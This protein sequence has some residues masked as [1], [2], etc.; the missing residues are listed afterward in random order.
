MKPI[1]FFMMPVLI[2]FFWIHFPFQISANPDI[3]VDLRLYKGTFSTK[4]EDKITVTTSY[5]LRPIS[6]ETYML[7]PNLKEEREEI[8]KV[9]N[10]LE[11][12]L[13]TQA[14]WGWKEGK[15][16]KKFQIIT[17]D[18]REF[19]L[20]FFQLDKNDT[21]KL[22]VLEKNS[23][24]EKKLLEAEIILPKEK[25]SIFGFENS[26]GDPYFISLQRGKDEDIQGKEPLMVAS[27]KRP[28]LIRKIEPKY[29]KEAL[30]N[31][32]SGRV[33]LQCTTDIYG[34]VTKVDLIEGDPVLSK[35]AIE[36]LSQ[37]IY[38]PYIVNN[39]PTE[40][41]FTV[42]TTFHLNGKEKGQK[43][44][45]PEKR[46]EANPAITQKQL[47][48]NLRNQTFT[49]EPMDFEF[50]NA[51]LKNVIQFLS[52]VTNLNMNLDR[53]VKGKVTCKFKQMPWDKAL[54][55]FL[56]DNGLEIILSDGQLR[57]KKQKK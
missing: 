22:E 32:I 18:N 50:L 2:L 27:I 53:N 55:I 46:S 40:V 47:I 41:K 49:G 57:I 43:E 36:A 31:K 23:G 26:A 3:Q 17:L 6:P 56:R 28:K 1:K 9:F 35:A 11:L 10:L 25:T 24:K 13:I 30:L 51:D 48:I 14:K 5:F 52:T 34:R 12:K 15:K 20:Q 54:A 19:V 8:K 33:I 42:I 39:K 16:T 4:R 38:E 45:S 37:W 7:D 44:K 29:P 21:F